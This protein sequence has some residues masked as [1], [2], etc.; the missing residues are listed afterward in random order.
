MIERKWKL[1]EDI[2]RDDAIFDQITFNDIILAIHCNEKVIDERAIRKVAA[3]IIDK[4]MQDFIYLLSNNMNEIIAEAA[5]GR[6]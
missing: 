6:K 1:N 3:E 5:K 4:R 2:H